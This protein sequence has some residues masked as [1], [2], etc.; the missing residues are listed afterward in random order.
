MENEPLIIQRKARGADIVITGVE[1]LIEIINTPFNPPFHRTIY[2]HIRNGAVRNWFERMG[3]GELASLMKPFENESVQKYIIALS[4]FDENR[5]QQKK[6]FSFVVGYE[7]AKKKLLETCSHPDRFRELS[8][9]YNKKAGGAIILY[10]PPG[11]GKTNLASSL[12]GETSKIFMKRS[13]SDFF[14]PNIMKITLD[15]LKKITNTVLFIDEIEMLGI[16][17]DAEGLNSRRVTNDILVNI[18]SN[19]KNYGILIVGTTNTPWV[20]DASVLRSGRFDE[21]IYIGLPSLE[22]REKLFEFYSKG[23]P[24]DGVEFSKISEKTDFYSCSDIEAICSEAAAI[25]WREAIA[26]KSERNI[27]SKDFNDA[28]ARTESTAIPWLESTSNLMLS[29]NMKSRFAPMVKEIE[30]YKNSR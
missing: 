5:T 10:G 29:H 8:K 26:G 14:S 11:C 21:L 30:R 22:E 15:I 6:N 17:R 7:S 9:K 20:I 18:D 27:T 16:D 2:E 19:L 25:P 23:L 13:G 24:L 3:E 28:L 1:D 4:I 12:A